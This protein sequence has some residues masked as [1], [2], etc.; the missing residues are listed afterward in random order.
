MWHVSLSPMLGVL[1]KLGR[2]KAPRNQEERDRLVARARDQLEGVGQ[3]PDD[4]EWTEKCLH[5][6]RA[7]S[8]GE[9]KIVGPAVDVRGTD[10]A[11]ERWA[12]VRYFLPKEWNEPV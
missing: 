1:G 6:R 5:V 8:D 11:R 2:T 7:I 9:A 3:G 4:L 12:K 10:E